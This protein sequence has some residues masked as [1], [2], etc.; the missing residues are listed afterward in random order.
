MSLPDT[1]PPGIQ[2]ELSELRLL[3]AFL[4]HSSEAFFAIRVRDGRVIYVNDAAGRLYGYSRDELLAMTVDQVSAAY[5]DVTLAERMR[6]YRERGRVVFETL[7]R[8]KDGRQIPVEVSLGYVPGETEDHTVGVVRSL[9]ERRRM[10][11]ALAEAEQ[12]WQIAVEAS[13]RGVWDWQ[14]ETGHIYFSARC[15]ALLGFPA[16]PHQMDRE[17][18]FS[19]V[20]LDDRAAVSAAL[21]AH[22]HGMSEA[23]RSEHRAR[24]ADG[25]FTWV[26]SVGKVVGRD[27]V[28]RPLRMAGTLTDVDARR[29]GELL[30]Q[31]R[32]A[33]LHQVLQSRRAEPVYAEITQ[34][35]EA[36]QSDWKVSI[37]VIDPASRRM[38]CVSAPSLPASL[39]ALI[40]GLLPA[41]G[42]GTCGT[43]IA[44]GERCL[45]SDILVDP[46]WAQWHELAVALALR[47]CWSVPFKDDDGQVRGSLAVYRRRPGQPRQDELEL[48]EEFA[49]IAALAEQRTRALQ[50]KRMAAA[51]FDNTH[52]GVVITDL[53][54]AIVAANQ[55]F[56][57][58]SGYGLEELLGQ[59]PSL[60]K[61]GRHGAEFYADM[62]SRLTEQGLWQG[63]IWNRRKSGEIYP[64]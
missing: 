54:P 5:D 31:T 13:N 15:A 58:I 64:Q 39:S 3:E 36:V 56:S 18:W 19:Q 20:H 16:E 43:A 46:G 25:G 51:V 37:I 14:A 29:R 35:M 4:G 12:R 33:V 50:T 23:F 28:G 2:H 59:N 52:D 60:L 62:W 63:E 42:V 11:A 57:R 38:Q 40:G 53:K 9:E 7:H 17:T 26:Q 8:T 45:T 61:S 32:L 47:A 24:N 1:L 10:A 30:Q 27:T 21:D 44:S 22:F 48:I 49:R 41:P 34:R 55:A 6:E